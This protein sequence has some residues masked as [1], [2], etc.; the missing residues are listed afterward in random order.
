MINFP[1]SNLEKVYDLC[2]VKIAILY[3]CVANFKQIISLLCYQYITLNPCG[4][5]IL[6]S[7]ES[8]LTFRLST[9]RTWYWKLHYRPPQLSPPLLTL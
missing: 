9:H 1:H 2:Q 4:H 3:H 7:H 6:L 8:P 5:I